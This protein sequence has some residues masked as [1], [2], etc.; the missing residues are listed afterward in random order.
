MKPWYRGPMEGDEVYGLRPWQGAR[1]WFPRNHAG[2]C[3]WDPDRG[4]WVVTG[5]R[6]APKRMI[7][8]TWRHKAFG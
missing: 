2:W 1:I 3:G 5:G 6:M 7:R 4:R 8:G